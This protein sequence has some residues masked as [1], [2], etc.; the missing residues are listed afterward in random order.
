MSD[1]SDVVESANAA[2]GR[3][4]FA[5]ARRLY[6]SVIPEATDAAK[7]AIF[8]NLG[9]A[10]EGLGLFDDALGV[11]DRAIEIDPTHVEAWHNKAV[12]LKDHERFE[13][14]LECFGQAAAHK[15]RCVVGGAPPHTP[16]AV[17]RADYGP[18]S[19]SLLFDPSFGAG[20]VPEPGTCRPLSATD[21]DGLGRLRATR[22]LPRPRDPARTLDARSL[23]RWS[24]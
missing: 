24:G 19:S 5:E 20:S 12:A 9:A 6:E 16:N 14:A 22:R 7:P 18:S 23:E 4:D 17:S 15:V 13:E 8:T 11:Y 3:G 2:Y 21:G 1:L 10:L